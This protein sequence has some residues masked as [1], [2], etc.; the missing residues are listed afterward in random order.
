MHGTMRTA[1]NA[2]VWGRA[3]GW[4]VNQEVGEKKGENAC[5]KQSAYNL[6]TPKVKSHNNNSGSKAVT[7][8]STMVDISDSYVVTNVI[9]YAR[10]RVALASKG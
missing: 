10:H 4:V 1:V 5:P 3:R 9:G 8:V 2:W 6:K 7:P